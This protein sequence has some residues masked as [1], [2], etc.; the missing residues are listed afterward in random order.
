[1]SQCINMYT[2]LSLFSTALSWEKF[3]NQGD[4]E[5]IQ[6]ALDLKTYFW[7]VLLLCQLFPTAMPLWSF[8]KLLGFITV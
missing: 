8:I 2:C 1:M 6:V 4:F 5:A 3:T 7:L